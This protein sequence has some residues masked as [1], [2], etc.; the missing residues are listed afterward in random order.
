MTAGYHVRA[1]HIVQ[2][3]GAMLSREVEFTS[4][5][6]EFIIRRVFHVND[7]IYNGKLEL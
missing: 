3:V 2:K 5:L 6:G 4:R 1:E 7:M